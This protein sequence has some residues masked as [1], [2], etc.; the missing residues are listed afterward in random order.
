MNNTLSQHTIKRSLTITQSPL[1]NIFKKN[2]IY[3]SRK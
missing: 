3:A 2:V 1:K